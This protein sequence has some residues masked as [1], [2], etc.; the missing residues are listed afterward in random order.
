MFLRVMSW[1][2]HRLIVRSETFISGEFFSAVGIV[3]VYSTRGQ[4]QPLKVIKYLSSPITPLCSQR[5]GCADCDKI[6]ENKFWN[7]W[8]SEHNYFLK[9][10]FWFALIFRT[11][12]FLKIKS[13]KIFCSEN[14]CKSKMCFQK[15]ILFGKSMVTKL[16]FFHRFWEKD[17]C[18]AGAGRWEQRC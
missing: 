13:L 3:G 4:S 12:S 1:D 10:H 2:S 18:F 9:T 5:G 8:F 16:V 17:Y 7:H 6:D 11:K 15:I 14:Q